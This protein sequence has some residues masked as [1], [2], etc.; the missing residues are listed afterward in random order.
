MET[1]AA[2][3][4][5][6]VAR[7]PALT[8]P[9]L[10]APGARLGAGG[11]SGRGAGPSAP[12]LLPT[13]GAIETAPLE[14]PPPCLVPEQEQRLVAAAAVL[15]GRWPGRPCCQASCCHGDG[16]AAA[17]VSNGG[18]AMGGGRPCPSRY[19][20]PDAMHVGR[21][22]NGGC[23]DLGTGEGGHGPDPKPPEPPPVHCQTTHVGPACTAKNATTTCGPAATTG[24][25]WW[26]E[27]D[28]QPG[29]SPA[30]FPLGGGE[31]ME[32][33]WHWLVGLTITTAS[34]RSRMPSQAARRPSP[35][36][37]REEEVE[38]R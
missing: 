33:A 7:S 27:Q 19:P 10:G 30:P 35:F 18:G 23:T 32:A 15:R 31:E 20:G 1:V 5:G 13:H 4:L 28:T 2:S 37:L 11:G 21:L 22:P 3:A 29:S 25:P 6:A 8:V 24:A 12:A 36:P 26:E 38:L 34:S 9:F 14:P 17:M 16:E